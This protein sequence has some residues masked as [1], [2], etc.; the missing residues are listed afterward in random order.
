VTDDA[1]RLWALW[2]GQQ[3]GEGIVLKDRRTP[4]R[5]GVRSPAWLKVKHRVTLRV[6]VR[7]GEPELV[8]W[9]DWGWAA[10]VQLAYTHPRTGALTTIEELV[11][12][13]DPDAWT[14]RL[15][16]ARVLCWGILPSGRLR[17]PVFVSDLASPIARRG[18]GGPLLTRPISR[19]ERRTR[20]VADKD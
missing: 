1:A 4:Y 10:R 15:G 20:P 19:I 12:V 6:R 13:T 16:E 17:H 5:P 3:G 9:S 7:A 8:R 14:L 2:V 11:R 18:H